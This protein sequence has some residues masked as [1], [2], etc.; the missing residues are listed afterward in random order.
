ML[1]TTTGRCICVLVMLALLL[2]GLLS[3][4]RPVHAGFPEADTGTDGA[5]NSGQGSDLV[6]SSVGEDHFDTGAK[7]NGSDGWLALMIE[8]LMSSWWTLFIEDPISAGGGEFRQTWPLL[9]LGGLIPLD[10]ILIYGPDLQ[11]KSPFNDGRTQ[12]PPWL[13]TGALTSNTIIR[14]VEFE[15]RTVAPS[16]AYINV[17]V[18][19]DTLVLRDDGTGNFVALGPEKYQITRIGNYYYLMDPIRE[20]VYIFRSRWAGWDFGTPVVQYIRR[21]GEV[22]Y[23][24]D[25]NNNSLS[26]TYNADNLPTRIEDGLGRSLELTYVNSADIAD[27]HLS[28]VSDGYG[29]T[30]VINY[31]QMTCRGRQEEVVASF[32]DPMGQTTTM[33]HYDPANT[34]CNL[35]QKI[36]RPMGNSHIDQTWTQNPHGVDAVNS[37]KDAYGNETT[38]G[39][40]EDVNENIITTV[41]H[42]DGSQRVFHHERERY[43]LDVTDETGKQ[44]TVGYND[45]WQRTSIT[46][47]LGDTTEMAYHDESGKIATYTDAEGNTTTYTYTA[48]TQTFTN[49]DNAEAIPFTFYNLTQVDYPDDSHEIFAY[50][51]RGNVVSY[52]NQLSSTW[53]T[54][55]NERGQPLTITN[56]EGGVTTYT[57]YADATL[58][59][60][61]DSDVGITTYAYDDYKRLSTITRPDD[62]TV[63]FTYDLSDRLLSVTDELSR[64]TAF[65]YDANGN[66]ATA[67]DPLGLT[68]TYADDLMDRVASITDTVGQ[69]ANLSYDEL[70]RLASI[71]NRN[72]YTTTYT[73]DPR[74]WLTGVTDPLSNAWTTAYDDEGVPSAFATPLGFTTAF[75]T[76]K[77]GRTT[78]IT[79]PVG[80][81]ANL[82]Y[83]ELGR[84]TSATNREGRTTNYAYD[85]GGWLTGVTHPVIGTATYTRNDLGLPTR[86]TDQWGKH[87][88]FGYSPMG[89]TA[90]FTDPLG[91]EWTYAYDTRGRL[92]QVAYPDT[93]ASIFTY[94]DAGQV[95]QV[96]YASTRL[97]TGPG[98]P[99]LDYTYDDAGRLLTASNL[100]LTYDQRGDVTN[101]QDGA[102]SFGATYDDGRRLET[103]TYD[104]LATVTYTYDERD[105][106]TRVEDDLSGAWMTFT[107]DDDSRLTGITRSNAVDT[108][109]TYDSAGR[110]TRIEDVGPEDGWPPVADQQFTLNAEG[111]VIGVVRTLPL[112]PAPAGQAISLAFDDASQISSPGYA[113]D[114]RGC[115]IAAPGDPSSALRLGS[116]QGSGRAFTYDGASRLIQATN[117]TATVHLTYNGLNDVRTRT[118]NGT[119]TTYYHNYA[120]GLSPVVA[121][122][123]LPLSQSWERVQGGEGYK[124]FYVYTPSGSLLYS[125]DP[126]SGEVRFY[127][128]DRIGSTLFLTDG[129]GGVRDAYGYD[130]YGVLLSHTGASD[131]PFTYVGR[132]GVRREPVGELYD[133]RARYYDPASAR[134][135][136][137]DPVWP[138]LADPQSLNAYQYAA[139]NPLRY[140]DPTGMVYGFLAYSLHSLLS[141][142]NVNL[143][144][145]DYLAIEGFEGF[146]VPALPDAEL[147]EGRYSTVIE[148]CEPVVVYAPLCRGHAKPRLASASEIFPDQAPG[149]QASR[150]AGGEEAR[151]MWG[152]PNAKTKWLFYQREP[153]LWQRSEPATSQ[154]A[155]TGKTLRTQCTESSGEVALERVNFF[156]P[157]PCKWKAWDL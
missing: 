140:I 136:T 78:A 40:T 155:A 9:S 80:Q 89:R 3:P 26:Y 42:P 148:S 102:A 37:Q 118:A 50:D 96:A 83:D 103:A 70:G 154:R 25:R 57:Y 63:H 129:G 138:N 113:Y 39:F 79:D 34:N 27:R 127:H 55:Y 36:N 1:S 6:S 130:P 77:L 86:I 14:I 84:L 145:F 119:T 56:P 8:E 100:T 157:W 81:V 117:G 41:T 128:F 125:I 52:T 95:T 58:A 115:Q 82:S 121:E 16:R 132:Y 15:D 7:E 151:N 4:A 74:G 29:R 112:D 75:Q 91:N 44:F 93:T 116:G 24:L 76:D 72:G 73:Y 109:F 90:V 28:T 67:T 51:A 110:V 111:D 45:D 18:S 150:E 137:R 17:F 12:F 10:F 5:K 35:L 97:S 23:I 108:Y 134:F 142:S 106:L 99:T 101:S 94:D 114:A 47:R 65:T 48:Q 49:P 38:L 21:V 2:T 133:M 71:T 153:L 87:W 149:E 53:T 105:L 60:S 123:V 88:D 20:R 69:V 61:T 13:L 141:P 139:Q 19:N 147:A 43:P 156:E 66:L 152:D 11:F 122:K 107:Y 46:D 104:G 120:L 124:R 59:S 98:G 62:S 54:T 126:A 143:A 31:Q 33:E 22:V 146:Y 64:T 32:T 68:V 144:D 30:V 135:L 131:Q 92:D 85:D